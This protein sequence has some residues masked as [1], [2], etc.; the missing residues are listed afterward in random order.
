[1][2]ASRVLTGVDEGYDVG[3]VLDA[4]TRPDVEFRHT[5]R[6]SWCGVGYSFDVEVGTSA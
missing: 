6:E 2:T 3:G 5:M 4:W 1:M